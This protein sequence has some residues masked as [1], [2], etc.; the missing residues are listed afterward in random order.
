MNVKL[1]TV[2]IIVVAIMASTANANI[3]TPVSIID[4]GYVAVNGTS[5]ANIINGNG[6]SDTDGDGILGTAGDLHVVS[7]SDLGLHQANELEMASGAFIGFVLDQPRDI[8]AIH[9]WNNTYADQGIVTA[10]FG[11]SNASTPLGWTVDF[12]P[13]AAPGI[14]VRETRTQQATD[15]QLLADAWLDVEI[16]WMWCIALAGPDS[17]L[18]PTSIAEIRFEEVPEPATMAILG[19]GG[20]LISRRRK[21]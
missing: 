5:H 3:I 6:L 1:M 15:G 13:D 17:P 4:N 19:L 7:G 12:S 10:Y 11:Y 8:A 16:V 9:M 21:A 20:L 14:G 2:A 18:G